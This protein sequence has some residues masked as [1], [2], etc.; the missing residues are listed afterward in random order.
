MHRQQNTLAAQQ[1]Q[2]R[3]DKQKRKRDH[4]DLNEVSP[5]QPPIG[6]PV[7][8]CSVFKLYDDYFLN[9]GLGIFEALPVLSSQ[10]HAPCFSHA[11]NAAALASRSGQLH[12]SGVLVRARQAY[13]DAILTL[14][15][16]I[17]DLTVGGDDSILASLFVLGFFE[18]CV[19][20]G[21]LVIS[22][23]DIARSWFSNYLVPKYRALA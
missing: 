7:T 10:K 22:A 20:K 16:S 15:R 3:V 8:V 11:L 17:Q 4:G 19:P 12:Q 23:N 2:A 21:I 14:R 13:G 6:S 9:S 18:V 1:V 5:P